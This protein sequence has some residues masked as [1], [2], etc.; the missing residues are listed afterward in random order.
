VREGG[1]EGVSEGV[2]SEGGRERGVRDWI[3]NTDNT[4]VDQ[5]KININS[6]LSM[7]D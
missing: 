6:F 4:T 7:K 5:A 1:R 3:D 2:R